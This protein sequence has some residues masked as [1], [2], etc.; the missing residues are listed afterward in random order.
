VDLAYWL[1]IQAFNFLKV[2]IRHQLLFVNVASLADCAFLCWA[3]NC[4]DWYAT[5]RRSLGG[6]GSLE[7]GQ[8]EEAGPVITRA[9]GQGGEEGQEEEAGPVITGGQM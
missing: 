4:E 2:P 5:A 9:A 8:E 7:A 1:P 3:N 6:R